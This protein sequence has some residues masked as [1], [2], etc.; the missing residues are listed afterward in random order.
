MTS[1]NNYGSQYYALPVD[2]DGSARP[3]AQPVL[4]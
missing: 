4:A 3:P 2:G 1:V